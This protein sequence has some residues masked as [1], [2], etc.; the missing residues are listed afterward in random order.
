MKKS[1]EDVFAIT[2]KAILKLDYPNASQN[3]DFIQS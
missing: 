3:G 1:K 2:Q